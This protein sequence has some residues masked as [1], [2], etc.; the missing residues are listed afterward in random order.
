MTGPHLQ[1]SP[2]P[3]SQ[4]LPGPEQVAAGAGLALFLASVLLALALG[5]RADVAVL[6]ATLTAAIAVE[7]TRALASRILR[8]VPAPEAPPAEEAP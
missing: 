7:A 3:P 1:Q 8:P 6:H 2:R 5:T 4:D